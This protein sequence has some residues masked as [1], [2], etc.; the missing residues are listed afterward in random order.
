MT[1]RI[2]LR[3]MDQNKE[4]LK[5]SFLPQYEINEKQ[6]GGLIYA[7]QTMAQAYIRTLSSGIAVHHFAGAAGIRHR[8]RLG[9]RFGSNC[10]R[11]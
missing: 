9:R 7:V 10:R 6:R 2:L 5:G 11:L 1:F 3:A 4:V 8:R